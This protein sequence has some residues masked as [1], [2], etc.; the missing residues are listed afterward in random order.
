P[1][2][3]ISDLTR[4]FLEFSTAI[5][6]SAYTL[7]ALELDLSL[8]LRFLGDRFVAEIALDDLRHFV[9]WL[10]QERQNDPRSLRRKVASVKAFFSYLRENGFRAD[11][12]AAA[13]IYPALDPHV[14]EILEASEELRLLAVADRPLWRA[15]LVVLLDA[16]LKRDEV[17]AL[18][19]ADIYLDPVEPS[20][21]YLVVRATDQARRLRPRTLGLTQRLA[22]ELGSGLAS[23]GERIFDIS[24]RGVNFIVETCAERAGLRKR[25]T[26]SPQMLR[27][28]YAWREVGRRVAVERERQLTGASTNDIATLRQRHDAEVCQIL[29][30]APGESNDPIR[31]YRALYPEA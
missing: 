26:V 3:R 14:P 21:G 18:H 11:D 17:L 10:R 8:L 7:E 28:T 25:G 9:I 23:D 1:A 5:D 27:D 6:R 4:R 19:P 31:R 12:P 15:L 16:G 13:L 2:G 20:R 24:V 29:G 22:K 30:L